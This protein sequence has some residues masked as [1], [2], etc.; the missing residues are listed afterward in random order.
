M[1]DMI[2]RIKECVIEGD[3]D[4]VIMLID[5]ALDALVPVNRIMTEGLTEAMNVVGKQMEC[6]DL[7]IPEVL[8]CA[9]TMKAGMEYLKPKMGDAEMKTLGKIVIGT[10]AGDLH[11]IGK[12]LIK[13]M[14]E[15]SGFE[16]I[17]I[18]ID[19]GPDKFLEIYEK[20]KPD[21]IGLSALLTT[22][23]VS[24]QETVELLRKNEV[25]A[26]IIVGGAP[27]TA[28][29]AKTINADGY[30]DD[31]GGAISLCKKLLNI[32]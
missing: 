5:Q 6:G 7:F 21:I 9:E 1:E 3:E 20:E 16:V 18:G 12:N 25:S 15:V 32:A 17:D 28:E 2:T 11:D 14:F 27:V 13:M 19:Q 4:S 22:T 8:M 26:K 24:M 30:S 23:M 31:A 29:F 10:V